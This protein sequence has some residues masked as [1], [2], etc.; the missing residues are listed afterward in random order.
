MFLPVAGDIGGNMGLFLGCSLLTVFEFVDLLWNFL[1]SRV[2][3][4]ENSLEEQRNPEQNGTG[5]VTL[6]HASM[7]IEEPQRRNPEQ[8]GPGIV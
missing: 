3:R 6:K 4:L 1:K 5:I 7:H 8:N 2:N